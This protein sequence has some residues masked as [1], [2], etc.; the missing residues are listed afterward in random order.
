VPA[1]SVYRMEIKV[2]NALKEG[3]NVKSGNSQRQE[4]GC[5]LSLKE[6]AFDPLPERTVFPLFSFARREGGRA[7]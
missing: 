2:A 4:K 7:G 5:F 1:P 6:T 3:F